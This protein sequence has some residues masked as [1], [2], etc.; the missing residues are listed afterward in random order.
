MQASKLTTVPCPLCGATGR[1]LRIRTTREDRHMQKYGDLYQ[2][3]SV[4]EWKACA[5]CGFVH[6]NPR[7]SLQSLLEFYANG[8]YHEPEIPG[9]VA[10]Y[11]D[12]ALW[13]Y[14]EKVDYAVEKSHL[15]SGDVFEVGCGLGGALWIFSERGYKVRGVEPD[16]GQ[17][18]FASEALKLQGV[19]HGL[20]D[21]SLQLD[22][23]VDLVFSNHAFEHF[24][25]LDSVMRAVTRILKPGGY[26]FTAVPTFFS[27]RSRLS[28]LWMNSA[29]YSLFTHRSLNQLFARYGIEPVCH[30]YRGWRKEI[31]DLWHLG[32]FCG[33]P[34][35]PTVF[36]EKPAAVQRYVN[37]YNPLRSVI[38]APIY[39]NHAKRRYLTEKYVALAKS[40]GRLLRE[41]PLLFLD[42]AVKHFARSVRSLLK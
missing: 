42:R 16:L 40:Y 39:A 13:Y 12:F 23:K 5:R 36:F 29:H 8:R 9:G 19:Q 4:S 24:A 11:R 25:D 17:A 18:R 1:F 10:G 22:T 3:I 20:L 27:N 15:A 26:V 34:A 2:G 30:T 32:R 33:P 21:D 6:Q 37:L 31:D 38:Y 41:S 7:P 14:S 28:K 35:D